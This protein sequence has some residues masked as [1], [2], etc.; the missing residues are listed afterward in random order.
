M[1]G[2]S[3]PGAA[4]AAQEPVE[5]ADE[6]GTIVYEEQRPRMFDSVSVDEPYLTFDIRSPAVKRLV[7]HTWSHD[8]GE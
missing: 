4:A 1:I 5:E 7:F 2:A 3:V 8:Q 6:W